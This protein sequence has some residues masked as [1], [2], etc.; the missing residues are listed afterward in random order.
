MSQ[1]LWQQGA[2]LP[3][4]RRIGLWLLATTLVP[5]A[6]SGRRPLKL[7]SRLAATAS[8]GLEL[9]PQPDPQPP[10]T[11]RLQ[12]ID[13]CNAL[14]TSADQACADFICSAACTRALYYAT[15]AQTACMADGMNPKGNRAESAV[16]RY[17][18]ALPL[19][20]VSVNFDF[21][22]GIQALESKAAN[23]NCV[24][25]CEYG[26]GQGN[27]VC[28]HGATCTGVISGIDGY[29]TG[30]AG[31]TCDC[32]VESALGYTGPTCNTACHNGVVG[33]TA[34]SECTACTDGTEPNHTH[35]ACLPCRPG[36]YGTGG[37][38]SPC[39]GGQRP[40]PHSCIDKCN[41]YTDQNTCVANQGSGCAYDAFGSPSC[42]S[43]NAIPCTGYNL[44]EASGVTSC[45]TSPTCEYI[46]ALTGCEK[47][48]T[49]TFS[50]AGVCEKCPL[51]F[52]PS[53]AQDACLPMPPRPSNAIKPRTVVT[54][55]STATVSGEFSAGIILPTVAG[56]AEAYSGQT[57]SVEA[58]AGKLVQNASF[59]L[60]FVSRG[61][62]LGAYS[63]TQVSTLPSGMY[64]QAARV[65]H[66]FEVGTGGVSMLAN[67]LGSTLN[68][69]PSDVSV[70]R[71]R[72]GNF[73]TFEGRWFSPPVSTVVP[74]LVHPSPSVSATVTLAGS[75][76][77]VGAAGSAV[78]LEFERDFVIGMSQ[79]IGV[80]ASRIEV[81]G[82]S[83]GSIMVTF[84]IANVPNA[85]NT[86]DAGL[87]SLQSLI[88]DGDFALAGYNVS[89]VSNFIV[90][91][92]EHPCAVISGMSTCPG[93]ACVAT[94]C[95]VNAQGRRRAQI[96]APRRQLQT[97]NDVPVEVEFEVVGDRNVA[98]LLLSSQFGATI[99]QVLASEGMTQDTTFTGSCEC[100]SSDPS[101][102]CS[103]YPGGAA[104]SEA[105]C[106]FQEFEGRRFEATF[107]F[108]VVNDTQGNPF[109]EPYDR[110]DYTDEDNLLRCKEICQ[111][112][113]AC[114]AF[115]FQPSIN[116]SPRVSGCSFGSAQITDICTTGVSC[117]VEDSG[118]NPEY[119]NLYIDL[120][121]WTGQV[122]QTTYTYEAVN[123]SVTEQITTVMPYTLTWTLDGEDS[124]GVTGV[125]SLLSDAALFSSVL[126]SAASAVQS[127]MMVTAVSPVQTTFSTSC[128]SGQWFEDPY[129]YNCD[130]CQPGFEKT[131]N[132][133]ATSNSIC[134]PCAAVDGS[135]THYS[136]DGL[137][138]LPCNAPCLGGIEHEA[139]PC[140]PVANRQ[141][142]RCPHGTV[143]SR[144]CDWKKMSKV[145]PYRLGPDSR[146]FQERPE[147]KS[148]GWYK[149]PWKC[150][151]NQKPKLQ[152][153]YGVDTSIFPEGHPRAQSPEY[154]SKHARTH[155]DGFYGF[156]CKGRDVTGQRMWE[157][158]S[159]GRICAPQK[160]IAEGRPTSSS[161]EVV[162]GLAN[163]GNQ[164]T[165]CVC[166]REPVAWWSVEL[167]RAVT[168]PTLYVHANNCC[169][170]IT[171][172]RPTMTLKIS[173][174]ANY[175]DAIACGTYTPSSSGNH[176]G[177]LR[178]MGTGRR[179]FISSPGELALA[180]IQI[181]DL[182]QLDVGIGHPKESIPKSQRG[183]VWVDDSPNGI[184][185]RL[186]TF[187]LDTTPHHPY[188]ERFSNEFQSAGE[189]HV[190]QENHLVGEYENRPVYTGTHLSSSDCSH[191]GRIVT[192]GT[193]NLTDSNGVSCG[194]TSLRWDHTEEGPYGSKETFGPTGTKLGMVEILTD[195]TRDNPIHVDG[196]PVT[197]QEAAY[198]S[199]GQRPGYQMATKDRPWQYVEEFGWLLDK[200]WFTE[201]VRRLP[202][203][204]EN[205]R[206]SEL[207]DADATKIAA[208]KAS[209]GNLN[210][211]PDSSG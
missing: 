92:G 171:L 88:A 15:T 191:L 51:G 126:L 52:R 95:L 59:R 190:T 84:E 37:V 211:L 34:Q 16:P 116:R 152:R 118:D 164:V 172:P 32:S 38:C 167:P 18:A 62:S 50:T 143:A 174:T 127:I 141:C 158:T 159:G 131:S 180:E 43:T 1:L 36:T 79:N 194:R 161:S 145:Q 173:S 97:E 71:I 60:G 49:L 177:V 175:A 73:D 157:K 182:G 138:C 8:G 40:A 87:S 101:G 55:T 89:S 166:I 197:A 90:D 122:E 70:E 9:P 56:I 129:C 77:D 206:Q 147:L 14:F 13:D 67:S 47:C 75:V 7:S 144:V 139:I 146:L 61:S 17:I 28:N 136:L 192:G 181:F 107:A 114:T 185:S 78:R 163:D 63:S 207:T 134:T 183:A 11:R 19:L 65:R 200:T 99:S 155:G 204:V 68:V 81:T 82:V 132:C 184:T 176:L 205:M 137:Q 188:F 151:G 149:C 165:S 150:L 169:S 135:S 201:K 115:V 160:N 193:D 23:A 39:P 27:P 30:N 66:N 29:A 57:L 25:L 42:A 210:S 41:T 170:N 209:F 124:S 69:P 20:Q 162:S 104:A 110:P 113:P 120:R 105:A 74:P 128:P 153:T 26:D 24:N 102:L 140:T 53:P 202:D 46:P 22:T 31:Y 199:A 208:A 196:R 154:R 85:A 103:A 35:T 195:Y 123:I 125:A 108:L 76:T 198:I 44:D 48:P 178:C 6:A 106:V 86:A 33:N 93:G 121:T 96:L 203:S 119:Y 109:P 148:T 187:A 91:Y 189:Q 45:Q 72:V 186:G 142:D 111:N 2:E 156:T 64:S 3:S 168:N 21:Q 112:E 83:A 12:T 5:P 10:H 58:N 133:T 117:G 100:P 130:I 80:E 54:M 4:W 94:D 179:V 98:T